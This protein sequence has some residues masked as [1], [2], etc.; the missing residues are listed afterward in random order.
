MAQMEKITQACGDG[1]CAPPP[2]ILP[3]RPKADRAPLI[4]E[5][6][7]LE[8]LTIGWMVV[9]AVVGWRRELRPGSLVLV[10]LGLDKVIELMITTRRRER[11]RLHFNGAIHGRVRKAAVSAAILVRVI[12]PQ[13]GESSRHSAWFG[14]II[15]G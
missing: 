5:A 14:V 9:E 1:C 2:L 10:A 3:T 4:R 7:R 6:F 8:W 11:Y 13:P 15:G 12:S